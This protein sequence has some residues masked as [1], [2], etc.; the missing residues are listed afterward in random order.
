MIINEQLAKGLKN[1]FFL[2]IEDR[3]RLGLKELSRINNHT[4]KSSGG[5]V[6]L[7]NKIQSISQGFN[8]SFYEG[9]SKG[10]PYVGLVGLA[11]DPERQYNHW[12]EKCLSG[13]VYVQTLKPDFIDVCDSPFNIG[14]HAIARVYERAN[15][16]FFN[17]FDVDLF[18]IL[19]EFKMVPLW[20]SFWIGNI[21]V[22][23]EAFQ[24]KYSSEFFRP[25]IPAKS[26][27]FFGELTNTRIPKVEIRTFIHDK[28]LTD[29]QIALKKIM[30]S[31]GQGM[32]ASPLALFPL[33]TQLK[34]D[35]DFF[36]NQILV[37]EMIPHHE[38]ITRIIFKSIEEDKLRYSIKSDFVNFL[39]KSTKDIDANF[40]LAYRKL[41]VRA[42]QLQIKES[43]YKAGRGF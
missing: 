42:A 20:A 39:D 24:N 33:V 12:N 18:S 22:Y 14:E 11:I 4:K 13:M 28:N 35:T 5:W 41:G 38:L 3:V 21:G 31:L 1:R 25:V 8:I 43:V 26:G 27:L 34:I 19:P 36:Q 17:E 10:N 16:N 9:G 40:I 37:R 7:V 6:K 23:T 32:D 2:E 30:W 15:L 29:D